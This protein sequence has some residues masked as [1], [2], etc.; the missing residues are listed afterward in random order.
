MEMGR[1]N[2]LAGGAL[3]A[4]GAVA[5]NASA[6]LPGEQKAWDAYKAS[7]DVKRE[8]II[9]SEPLLQAPAPDS[10]GVGFAVNG[11]SVG[12]VEVADN[13]ELKGAER[14]Y[15]EGMPVAR[16]DDRVALVRMTGLKPATRYYYRLLDQ[17]DAAGMGKNLFLHHARRKGRFAFRRHQ[18]HPRKVGAVQTRHRQACGAQSPR[19]DLERRYPHFTLQKA[20]RYRARHV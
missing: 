2:F 18:R 15:A 19:D 4:A 14:F 7:P 13:P 12:F 1:R 20:R 3:L 16:L 17:A 10:M 11:M 9:D 5:K 8:G 6:M